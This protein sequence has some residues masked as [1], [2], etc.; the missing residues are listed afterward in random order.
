[1]PDLDVLF[2]ADWLDYKTLASLPEMHRAAARGDENTVWD[3]LRRNIGVGITSGFQ[4]T[5]NQS[6]KR[7]GMFDYYADVTVFDLTALHCALICGK[8]NCAGLLLHK[9]ARMADRLRF[10][11]TS[12]SPIF[13][14]Q[15]GDVTGYQLAQAYGSVHA[16]HDDTVEQVC[17]LCC[18]ETD[19]RQ[20]QRQMPCA[21]L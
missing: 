15:E 20:P 13:N 7:A 12:R 6:G 8:D 5:I 3:L 16:N 17:H 14:G 2:S 18:P 21:I 1:M 19:P 4:I 9:G 10:S 11:A